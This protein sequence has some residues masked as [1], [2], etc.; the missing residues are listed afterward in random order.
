MSCEAA[1]ELNQQFGAKLF[2]PCLGDPDISLLK[3]GSEIVDFFVN[4]RNFDDIAEFVDG[5]LFHKILQ[6][7]PFGGIEKP[8]ILDFHS[9]WTTEE[10]EYLGVVVKRLKTAEDIQ[11]YAFP[12]RSLAI[13]RNHLAQFASELGEVEEQLS[14]QGK[15]EF[16][17]EMQFVDNVVEVRPFIS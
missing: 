8:R 6:A 7:F 12:H 4:N 16:D 5:P 14:E 2:V 9:I 17:P 11:K 3:H 13:I 15:F 1:S 10:N